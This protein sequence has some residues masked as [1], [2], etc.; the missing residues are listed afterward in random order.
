MSEKFAVGDR[1][2][3]ADEHYHGPALVLE[4]DPAARARLDVEGPYYC[5]L[6]DLDDHEECDDECQFDCWENGCRGWYAAWQMRSAKVP[7]G[8]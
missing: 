5:H 1:V 6:L 7:T 3:V 8:S 2:F 4:I